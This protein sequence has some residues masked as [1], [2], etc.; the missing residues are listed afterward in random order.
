METSVKQRLMEFMSHI[1]ISQRRFEEATGLSNGYIN[2][3]RHAPS[4]TKLQKIFNTYPELNRTW[5]LTGEG[6]M[7]NDNTADNKEDEGSIPL[8]P[9][10]AMAGFL[11]SGFDSVM[12][13]DCERFIVPAFQGADFLIR[14]QGDSMEPRYMSGDIVACKRVPLDRLWFQWGKAYIIDTTQGALVKRIEP[15]D[16]DGFISIHSENTRYKPF[17]LP[18]T[19]INAVALIIGTIRVE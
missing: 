7:I 6:S 19:D 4:P 13:Y 3:L 2:N 1:N 9:V 14:V 12:P 18:T 16:R 15:S 8:I 17:D 10:Y 11:T 5:V